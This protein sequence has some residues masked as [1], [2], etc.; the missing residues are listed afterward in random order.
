MRKHAPTKPL[1]GKTPYEAWFHKKPNVT[2]L[3]EFGSPVYIL[4]QGNKELPKL[5]LRS[6]DYT[7]VG[8][9]DGAHSIKYYNAETRKVLTSC[10]FHFLN[11]LP[12]NPSSP[13]PILV[14]LGPAMP[15]EGELGTKHNTLQLG[16][17]H[18]K[19]IIEE[20]ENETEPERRKLQTKASVNYRFLNDPFPDEEDE[21]NLIAKTNIYQAYCETPLGGEDPKTLHEAKSSSNWPEWE[22]AIRVE[23]E[24]LNH[25]GTWELTNCP[26]DAVPI[27]NKWVF[28]KKYVQ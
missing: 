5:L 11:N 7:F 20:L 22:K 28:V 18:N 16:S 15:R 23:L 17:Q 1:Q 6:K 3:R 12:E 25:M 2:H 9:D 21:T 13:E 27:A 4:L 14:E 8:F 26:K 19:R 24:Q 10:N